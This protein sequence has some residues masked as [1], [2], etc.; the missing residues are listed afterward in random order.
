MVFFSYYEGPKVTSAVVSRN[1]DTMLS[2]EKTEQFVYAIKQRKKNESTNV[3]SRIEDVD[4]I[5]SLKAKYHYL[6]C[7]T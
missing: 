3:I 6:D 1:P 7:G 5:N 4:K 2:F